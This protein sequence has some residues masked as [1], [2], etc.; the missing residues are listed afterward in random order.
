M[1]PGANFRC[2]SGTCPDAKPALACVAGVPKNTCTVALNAL[3]WQSPKVD[4]APL[5]CDTAPTAA[6]E[7]NSR[8]ANGIPNE[9]LASV[10]FARKNSTLS[11]R[12]IGKCPEWRIALRSPRISGI[13]KP[14]VLKV[15]DFPVPS[16]SLGLK[17]N[18][19]VVLSHDRGGQKQHDVQRCATGREDRA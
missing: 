9:L 6:D 2:P 11:H 10:A 16:V 14:K 18:G 5:R 3:R 1:K 17:H 13:A 4:E 19:D 15:A 12:G 7:E 8:A